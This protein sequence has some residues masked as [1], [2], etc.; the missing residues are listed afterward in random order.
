MTLQQIGQTRVMLKRGLGVEDIALRL[1]VEVHLVR[2]RINAW[3]KSG[4][5]HAICGTHKVRNYRALQVL[6]VL[7]G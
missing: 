1:G 2:W 3:R 6:G 7:D 4:R 5:L